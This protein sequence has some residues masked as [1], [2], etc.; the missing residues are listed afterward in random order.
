MHRWGSFYKIVKRWRTGLMAHELPQPPIRGTQ[1]VLN[2][3]AG[4]REYEEVYCAY[5]RP[6]KNKHGAPRDLQTK[7]T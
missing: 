1:H 7:I 3:F 6:S 5:H 2:H 4:D